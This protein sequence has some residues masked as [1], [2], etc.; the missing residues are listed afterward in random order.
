MTDP[1]L[2][3]LAFRTQHRPRGLWQKFS[4]PDRISDLLK[5]AEAIEARRL[6]DDVVAQEARIEQIKAEGVDAERRI[7]E[8][9]AKIDAEVQKDADAQGDGS[10]VIQATADRYRELAALDPKV[11]KARLDAAKERLSVAQTN[12]RLH[13]DAHAIALVN[14]LKPEA[15]RVAK[16]R[17][18]AHAQARKLLDPPEREHVEIT[19]T[20]E[21]LLGRTEPFEP[22][23]IPSHRFAEIPFPSAE[24]LEAHRALVEPEPEPEPA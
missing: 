18:A 15:E 17:A 7:A 1:V 5:S 19:K 24:S 20:I 10:D 4:E 13:L 9:N 14:E 6:Y 2:D 23:D 8:A 21:T 16:Q 22:A 3:P 12:L 11:W